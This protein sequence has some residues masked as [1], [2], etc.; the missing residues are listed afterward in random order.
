MR[1][2][3]LVLPRNVIL[4]YLIITFFMYWTSPWNWYVSN[5]I[6]M[7]LIN[8]FIWLLIYKGYSKGIANYYKINKTHIVYRPVYKKKIWKILMV[9]TILFIYPRLLV[10]LQVDSITP[11]EFISTLV[12]GIGDLGS[13]YKLR[14][15]NEMKNTSI[16]TNIWMLIYTFGGPFVTF[17]KFVSIY[18]WR[19]ISISNKVIVSF[20]IIMEL[21]GYIAI[22]TNKVIFD[23]VIT[24]PFLFFAAK[25]VNSSNIEIK[26]PKKVILFTVSFFVAAIIFFGLTYSS[27]T[28]DKKILYNPISM[29][30]IKYDSPIMKI[31]PE[32]Y[33]IMYLGL[34]FYLSHAYNNMDIALGMDFKPCF[35]LGNS[36]FLN[37]LLSDKFGLEET[38]SER[39]YEN[40]IA[41]YNGVKQGLFWDT[42][43]V[44]FAN[45]VSFWG[46][47]VLLYFLA[48]FWGKVWKEALLGR[49]VIAI[50]LFAMMTICFFYLNANNQIFGKSQVLI[51]IPL[52]IYWLMRKIKI[53][54]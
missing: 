52:Y 34:D 48:Y 46:V 38:I 1:I 12:N 8:I 17:F 45:D 35:G 21:L 5:P 54:F 37:N 36:P 29:S 18:Y 44:A 20:A 7:V 11:G 9:L 14:N 51:F 26:L 24:L 40:R 33:Q 4:L 13:A 31:I 47:P 22:G 15:E 27:R 19:K 16:F 41:G 42:A 23:Y 32:N 6:R 39:T 3:L 28:K 10:A 2:N 30:R 49:K 25:N 53:K 43:Y 50:P